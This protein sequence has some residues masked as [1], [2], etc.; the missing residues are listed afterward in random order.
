VEN[1]PRAVPDAKHRIPGVP[2]L[3]TILPLNCF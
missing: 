3:T 2:G 1:L